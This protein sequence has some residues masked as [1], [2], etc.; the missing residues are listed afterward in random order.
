MMKTMLAALAL[1][2]CVPVSGFAAPTHT[3]VPA[4]ALLSTN[5]SAA[6]LRLNNMVGVP[7]ANMYGSGAGPAGPVAAAFCPTGSCSD[8][9]TGP[10]TGPCTP[11]PE[12]GTAL[13]A[14]LGFAGLLAGRFSYGRTQRNRAVVSA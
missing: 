1:A 9:V 10:V 11:S 5:L 13:L 12:N 14:I 3:P 7:T 2:L 4:G 8:P 6:V